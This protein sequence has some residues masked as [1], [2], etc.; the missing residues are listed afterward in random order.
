MQYLT[1]FLKTLLSDGIFGFLSMILKVVACVNIKH[2]E[3]F[4]VR[5]N[6]FRENRINV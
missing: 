1:I 4:L 5:E 3:R 2:R 6:K